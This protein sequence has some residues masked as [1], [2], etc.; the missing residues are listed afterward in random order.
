MRY[1]ANAKINFTLDIKG[2]REDGY[3]LID[4]VM[5]SVSLFD[6][7][8]VEKADKI[9]VICGDDEISGEKNIAFKAAKEFFLYTK[10]NG[11]AQINIEKYIPKAAGL[12]GGSADAAAVI[13]G[14][15]DLYETALTEEELAHI[16]LKVGADV[17]FCIMGGTVRA[18]GIGEILEKL[19]DFPKKHIVIVKNGEKLSTK[20]MYEKIDNRKALKSNTEDFIKYLSQG[21]F[22]KALEN[23]GNAF[24][25]VCSIQNIEE[26]AKDFNPLSVGLSGSGP[27]VYAVFSDEISAIKFAKSLSESGLTPYLA[28]ISPFG[29]KETE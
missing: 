4:S 2:K 21:D 26:L 1:I 12:G 29:V 10:I 16:G 13:V 24:K 18:T 8:T 19:P 17:P 15:N 5:Q 20:E 22:S 25:S 11:G 14:L 6:I 27:S 23:T 3:H 9:S 7:V 28:E